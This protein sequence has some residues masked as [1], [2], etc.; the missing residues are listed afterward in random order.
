MP[1]H[2]FLR[3]HNTKLSISWFWQTDT[4]RKKKFQRNNQIKLKE[5]MKTTYIPIFHSFFACSTPFVFCNCKSLKIIFSNK[6]VYTI[7]Y[8]IKKKIEQIHQR[9]GK[10]LIKPSTWKTYILILLKKFF[11]FETL[12]FL[13]VKWKLLLFWEC[14]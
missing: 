4:T 11:L 2:P 7:Y 8:W 1:P 5:K 9:V 12:T 3:T 10:Y 6:K 13:W 14:N